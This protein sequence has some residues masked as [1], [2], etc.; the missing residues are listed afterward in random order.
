MKGYLAVGNNN[1]ITFFTK[2][3][4]KTYLDSKVYAWTI[5]MG[6]GSSIQLT[7]AL[8]AKREV[9]PNMDVNFIHLMDL[10]G[11]ERKEDNPTGFG[12]YKGLKKG[13]I[14]EAELTLT[15]KHK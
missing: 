3:P 6:E 8:N 5:K 11:F 2:K 9:L 7:S 14:Y 1:S 12:G 13:E 10:F 15:I 4:E